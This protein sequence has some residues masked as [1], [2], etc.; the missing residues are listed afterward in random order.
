MGQ[1]VTGSDP[2]IHVTH[3]KMVTHLIHNPLTHCR[4]PT[5]LPRKKFQDFSMI[6]Q[7][8]MRNFPGP[9]RSRRMLKYK[10]KRSPM[11]EGPRVGVGFLGREATS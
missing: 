8:P 9:F 2:L 1:W 5:L 7:D 3:P 10:E 11:P 6:F 4:V